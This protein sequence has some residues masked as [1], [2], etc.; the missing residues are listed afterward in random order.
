MAVF[1]VL[2]APLRAGM[3]SDVPTAGLPLFAGTT[4]IE[5]ELIGPIRRI[6]DDTR[7]RQAHPMALRT[8]G[9]TLDV[10]VRVR[11]HS[12]VRVCD[13]PPLQ[14][15]FTGDASN[16]PFAGQESL[17]LVTHCRND[18]GGTRNLL[19]EYSAYRAFAALTRAGYR[20][21]LLRLVY[22]DGGQ[23]PVA[24]GRHL[25]AFV[26]ESRSELAR[27]LAA[28]KVDVAA[29]RRSELA[30]RHAA[31]VFVF[32]YLIGNTDW[33]LVKAD[34]SD[35]CCHNVDLVR[36]EDRI[37]IIP[38]DF[39]QAGLVDAPYAR[40][41]PAVG[42]RRVTSRRYR[43]YCIGPDPVREALKHVRESRALIAAQLERVPIV[44]PNDLR[45]R[46]R[47]LDAFFAQGRDTEKVLARFEKRC[48]E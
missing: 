7:Q 30:H 39:D 48:L 31:L 1:V 36:V 21:R 46:M 15:R 9:R 45:T 16:T 5:A 34:A 23:K 27:R 37:Y 44:H 3:A 26:I 22:R 29:I 20:T 18:L 32:Q 14:I 6:I 42:V 25:Y 43:G 17:K 4:V 13:F 11:G 8:G 10:E 40:P 35:S 28:D 33:S 2:L 19:D 24:G 38:Y 41:D 47:Y 12:R